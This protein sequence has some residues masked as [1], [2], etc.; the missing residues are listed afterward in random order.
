MIIGNYNV[1]SKRIFNV[2][3]E[4]VRKSRKNKAITKRIRKQALARIKSSIS[5]WKNARVSAESA[6]MPNNTEIIR[7]FK[8]IEIDAHL[9]AL[10]QTLR[11]KVMANKFSIYT[12]DDKIDEESTKLFQKRWFREI[13]VAVVDADFYGFSLV[14]LKTIVNG[15][16][17]GAELVPRE[18]VIQQ[19]KGVKMNLGD[20]MTLV[21]YESGGFENWLIPI[22]KNNHLGLLDKAAPLVIKKKEVISAWSE[23]AELFGMPIRIGK[24]DIQNPEN[25]ENMEDMMENMGEAAWGVFNTDDEIELVTTSKSDISNM[26]DN[27]IARINSELSKLILLQTGTT[28]E[29]THVGSAKVHENLL[30][31][32]VESYIISVEDVTNEVVIPICQRHGI[33]KLGAY[34]KA[35]NEQKVSLKELFDMV[36]GLLKDYN[37]PADWIADT[38]DIPVEKK[39]LETPAEPNGKKP[40]EAIEKEP[41]QNKKKKPADVLNDKN[42]SLVSSMTAVKNLYKDI[43]ETC[44]H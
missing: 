9:W 5:Q 21:S 37:V 36:K 34:I 1:T 26:Y 41:Q 33:L 3:K 29:K 42:A 15:S 27:F 43:L 35:N 2:R 6:I 11:L 32:V 24:T 10:M 4:A 13:M 23:A 30:K 31:D 38:F 28:E 12:V 39:E 17:T 16:F 25:R 19:K 20:P 8:D 18:Y 44:S 40:I 14:Q 22:G 7:V